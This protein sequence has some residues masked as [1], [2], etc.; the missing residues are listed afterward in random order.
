MKKIA[1]AI[2]LITLG[3]SAPKDQPE[4]GN[5]TEVPKPLIERI[6]LEDFDGNAIE[7]SKLKG[8]VVFL[9]YWATWCKPCIKEMPSIDKARKMINDPDI[10]FI[11]ASDEDLAKIK[12][13]TSQFMFEF[14]FAHSTTSV[15]DLDIKALP[16]T[17]IIGPEGKIVFNEIGGRDWATDKNIM[18]IKSFKK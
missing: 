16:T 15:F 17:M 4:N 6:R 2:L 12:K 3:C 5:S 13:Y 1:I 10:V 11:V 9:N 7:L 14:T 18:L 8:K